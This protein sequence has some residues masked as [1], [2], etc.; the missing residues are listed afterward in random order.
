M[1]HLGARGSFRFGN[2]MFAVVIAV[3]LGLAAFQYAQFCENARPRWH[4]FVHD[5][6][7]HYQFAQELALA[8]R[9][10]QPVAFFSTLEK[11]KVWPPVHGLLAAAV[12]AV[13]GIDYRLAVLPSLLGWIATAVFGFLLARRATSSNGNAAGIIAATMILASPALRAYALDIMLESLGSGLTLMAIYFYAVAREEAPA[14]RTWRRLALT[15]TILFFEKYNYWLLVVL[16]LAAT[17]LIR[18]RGADFQR[19]TA[20]L[21]RS[22]W[23]RALRAEARQPFTWLC[24]LLSLG[25]LAILMFHPAPISL[26]GK[27]VSLYPPNNLLTLAYFALFLRLLLARAFWRAQDSARRQILLWHC[28]PVAISF[29]LPRRLGVFIWFLGPF[30]KDE[31]TVVPLAEATRSYFHWIVS[32]YHV[33]PWSALL[34]VI[35]FVLAVLSFSRLRPGG[36][37]LILF[38]GIAAVLTLLHPNQKSRYLHSWWPAVWVVGAA[39]LTTCLRDTGR[40]RRPLVATAAVALLAAQVPAMLQPGRASETG[41]RGESGSLLDL[42]D[43]YLSQLS[44]DRSLAIF[45]T[46]PCTQFLLWTYHERFP[47]A[48]QIEFPL[49]AYPLSPNE[50]QSR[51]LQWAATTHAQTIA[52]LDFAPDSPEYVPSAADYAGYHQIAQILN[53]DPRFTLLQ[54]RHF[55]EYGC[56]VTT[57]RRH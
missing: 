30:N 48:D 1:I 54:Q 21:R 26:G 12:L 50:V 15:L 11:A 22:D 7:G 44:G 31:R 46:V 16:A 56:T 51:V 19:A 34:A 36:R 49:Q 42:S 32:D 4:G 23:R 28:L 17:E 45:S 14:V 25:A 53:S 6:S 39:G 43:A 2:V 37:A 29:L 10:S 47:A 40:S 9:H 57:W 55:L 41:L 38:V 20:R 33:A 5:R 18:R 13:G 3:A 8:I 35:F 52:F 27:A 24:L